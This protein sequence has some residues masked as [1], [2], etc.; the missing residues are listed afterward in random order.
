MKIIVSAFEKHSIISWIK[1]KKKKSSIPITQDSRATGRWSN[2]RKK[3]VL[4]AHIRALP[5][6]TARVT[7]IPV[8]QTF[9]TLSYINPKTANK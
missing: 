9:N 6:C 4:A 5:R 2:S 7:Q 3:W 1:K 8:N